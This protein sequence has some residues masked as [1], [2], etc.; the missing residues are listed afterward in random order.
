MLRGV[1]VLVVG[2]GLAGLTAA[3]GLIDR[4]AEV[5]VIE[6]RNRLGG[7]VWTIRDGGFGD[8]PLEAGGELIDGDHEAIR[9]LCSDLGLTLQQILREGFGLALDLRGRVQLFKGQRQIWSDFKKLLEH[10]ANLFRADECNWSSTAA[11]AIGRHSLEALLRARQAP[12]EVRAMVQALRGFFLGDPDQLSALVGVE[13]SLNPRDPGHVSLWRIKDGSDRL[14]EKLSS[15]KGLTVAL[16]LEVKKAEQHDN[17]VSVRVSDWAG[18]LSAIKGDYLVMAAPAPIVRDMEF[19]PPLPPLLRQGLK[20][21]TPGPATKAH[22]LFDRAWWRTPGHPQAWGSNLDTGAVWEASGSKPSVLTLLAG[23]RASAGFR[24]L[25]EEGGPQRVVR[26]LSWLGEPEE[27]RD[28]RS[29]TWEFDKFARGGYSVFG[30]EFRPEW[31]IELARAFGRIVF[32]GDHTSRQWQ[33][34]MNGAVESGVRAARD[35]EVISSLAELRRSPP[36]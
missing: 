2:G 23:G 22:V 5:Q 25:L 29:T 24:G 9:A 12:D 21:L 13:L 26:R 19:S 1:R 8:I 14:V 16:Q 33:G 36:P 20:A 11:S 34:Y 7:R 27:A 17:G 28:F 3:R 10:E 30:P 15:R 18:K 35:I 31:R 6:A 4:G 32:A